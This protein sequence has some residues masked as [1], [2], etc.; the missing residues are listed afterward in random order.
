M[1]VKE[2][3][4]QKDEVPLSE[5]MK[6]VLYELE[7]ITAEIEKLETAGAANDDFLTR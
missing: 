1:V 3:S 4:M 7:S 6:K 2:A 5:R